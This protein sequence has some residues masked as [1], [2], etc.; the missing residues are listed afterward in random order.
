MNKNDVIYALEV[1]DIQTVS[2]DLLE[3]DLSESELK[4]VISEV[5]K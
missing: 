5:E 2:Q 1:S 3:R 4:L